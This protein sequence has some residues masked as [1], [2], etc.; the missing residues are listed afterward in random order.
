MGKLVRII[1][2]LKPKVLITF[3]PEG[4]YGHYDHIAVHR[5]TSIAYDLA[6]DPGCFPDSA[7]AACAPHQV[8]K[9]Y[10]RVLPESQVAAMA[11]GGLPTSVMM[12]GVPFPMVG[13]RDEEITTVIDVRAYRERKLRGLTCHATQ[14][15]ARQLTGHQEQMVDGPLFTQEAF[16]LA[17]SMVGRPAGVESD[18]LWGL[19]SPP[20]PSPERTE[21]GG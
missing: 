12:D 8:S 10:Y 5:W 13:W 11:Q 7:A 16:V 9:L 18:L 2:E 6:A 17:R 3:G 21:R 14:F 20:V 4:I 1:R 15:D 19:P